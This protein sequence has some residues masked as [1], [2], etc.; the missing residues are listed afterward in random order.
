MD[1]TKGKRDGWAADGRPRGTRGSVAELRS[2]QVL[3]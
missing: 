3:R 1:G 2:A